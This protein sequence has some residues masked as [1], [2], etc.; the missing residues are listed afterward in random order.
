MMLLEWV[1]DGRAE[2]RGLL[3]EYGLEWDAE[4]LKLV[5]RM[6]RKFILQ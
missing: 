2:R 5:P 1:A 4:L 6:R 3:N